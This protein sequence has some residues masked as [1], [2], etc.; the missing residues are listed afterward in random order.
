MLGLRTSE[1]PN[2]T[3]RGKRERETDKANRDELI[4]LLNQREDRNAWVPTSELPRYRSWGEVAKNNTGTFE[5]KQQDMNDSYCT[6]VRF[7]EHIR[8]YPRPCSS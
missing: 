2:G 7:H 6:L 8:R 5:W 4:D 3:G 1:V